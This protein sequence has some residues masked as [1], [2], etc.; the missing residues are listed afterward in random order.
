MLY[1]VRPMVSIFVAIFA[2]FQ[3]KTNG[4]TIPMI[5]LIVN[6]ERIRTWIQ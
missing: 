5:I 1:H 2:C 4:G 6:T 3:Q